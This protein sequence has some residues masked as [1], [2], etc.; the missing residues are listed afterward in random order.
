[1]II[2][3]LY[4]KHCKSSQWK[5]PLS[6]YLK[7]ERCIGDECGNPSGSRCKKSIGQIKSLLGFQSRR[8]G[9]LAL[10][11][12]WILLHTNIFSLKCPATHFVPRARNLRPTLVVTESGRGTGLYSWI[13]LNMSLI[14]LTQIWANNSDLSVINP[15]FWA[16]Q[17]LV[18]YSL[19]Q[20]WVGNLDKIQ[21]NR[22]FFFVRQSLSE[23]W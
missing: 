18:E 3:L 21:K 4:A 16:N 20:I 9:K 15:Q 10:P 8:K 11:R 19:F 13:A 1:M 17:S 23:K 7:G 2:N 5:V 14:G 22:S 12:A 6:P